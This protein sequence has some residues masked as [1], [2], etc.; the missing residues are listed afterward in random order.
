MIKI[1]DY[2]YERKPESRTPQPLFFVIDGDEFE[3]CGAEGS[4]NGEGVG[5]TIVDS[6]GVAFKIR[7]RPEATIQLLEC[8]SR[9]GRADFFR[10]RNGKEYPEAVFGSCVD[11][12]ILM[13]HILYWWAGVPH[14]NNRDEEFDRAINPLPSLA[15]ATKWLSVNRFFGKNLFGCHYYRGFLWSDDR[16][17]S[18]PPAILSLHDERYGKATKYAWEREAE[19]DNDDE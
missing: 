1:V 12:R 9:S 16:L 8:F 19:D 4:P 14:Q 18:V 13:A 10:D 2:P 6:Q 5:A 11:A 17:D 15:E 3:F 7:Q